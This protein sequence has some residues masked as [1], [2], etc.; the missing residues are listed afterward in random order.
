MKILYDHQIFSLQNFGW[1]SRYFCEI[2]KWL[3]KI[4]QDVNFSTKYS[5][6]FYIQQ[7]KKQNI[8]P[9]L[10]KIN[11]KWKHILDFFVNK[12]FSIKKLKWWDFDL[13][14]PT[15][16][17]P[18]FLRYI[19]EKKYVITI[20]D[21]LHEIFPWK[22]RFLDKSKEYWKLIAE[23]SQRIIAVSENTKNDIIKYYWINPEKIDVIYHWSSFVFHEWEV[24]DKKYKLPEKYILFVWHRS[25][26][27]NFDKFFESIIPLLKADKELHLVCTGWNS[28][29][30]NE[31][32]NFNK[33]WLKNQIKHFFVDDENLKFFYKNAQIF[34]FPSLYE[35]FWIPILE[36]FSAQVPVIISKS[37]CFPEIAQNGALYFDPNDKKDIYN[38]IKKV[39]ESQ[40][41]RKELILKWN[42]RLKKFSWEISAKKTLETYK[43]AIQN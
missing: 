19:W 26:Y 31:L 20:H 36:A 35:W 11:F 13:F 41:L 15:F 2:Y 9:F 22:K 34:V 10:S 16:F 28:F 37:S 43:K 38:Q 21:M 23:K 39:L 5:N 25:W 30:E 42:E 33:S 32:K 24:I 18:Y 1:I 7:T 12:Y 8:K 6:N 14:H 40:N 27:K 17:H 4:W 3:N 29:D